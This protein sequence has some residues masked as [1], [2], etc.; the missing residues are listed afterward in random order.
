MLL[1]IR[2]HNV[3]TQKIHNFKT[4]LRCKVVIKM[5]RG[6]TSSHAMES[7][8]QL[9]WKFQPRNKVAP[10]RTVAADTLSSS[11]PLTATSNNFSSSA[12]LPSNLWASFSDL[13]TGTIYEYQLNNMIRSY[14]VIALIAA[15]RQH[16]EQTLVSSTAP[17]E[18]AVVPNTNILWLYNW[19]TAYFDV[20][21]ELYYITYKWWSWTVKCRSYFN[22]IE[23]SI[24]NAWNIMF[25]YIILC[26]EKRCKP[27][28]RNWD[29]HSNQWLS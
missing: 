21:S 27:W 14:I 7:A 15:H 13:L 19:L 6:L 2:Y 29:Q 25:I 28:S 1:Q 26:S 11:D 8:Q 24:P 20:L 9:T 17:P 4:T 10:H 23:M 22:V 16:K 5:T 12:K 18:N 3:R